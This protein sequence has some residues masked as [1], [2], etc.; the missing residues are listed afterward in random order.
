MKIKYLVFAFIALTQATYA[1]KGELAN[2]KSTY[3][4][5]ADLKQFNA[6]GFGSTSLQEAKTSIDK[7]VVH[8]K[9]INDPVAWGYKALIYTDLASLDS[10]ANKTEPLI[11]QATDAIKKASEL[12]NTGANKELIERAKSLLVRHQVNTGVLAY[13]SSRFNEAYTAFNKALVYKPGDTTVLYYTGLAAVNAK[14]YKAAIPN[15]EELLKTNYSANQRIYLD[16]SRLYALEKD[17]TAALRVASQGVSKYGNDVGLATQEIEL[18]LISGKQKEVIAKIISQVEKNPKD[19]L[20]PYY[21]GLAYSAINDLVK[22]EESYK[23]AIAI[24]STYANAYLNLGGLLLNKGIDTYNKAN[25]LPQNK[26]KEYDIMIKKAY[27]Q[28]DIAL[29]YLQK[30]VDL[31]PASR[32]GLENLKKYYIIK[33]NKIKSDELSDKIK[34][35]K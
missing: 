4:K 32:L 27:D 21:L 15:Y 26:Q 2:A 1:Q 10:V 5:Y 17:T 9:T 3:E 12:D 11:S 13:Q 28:F 16:L 14:N 30:A 18:S 34:V 22:A 8:V 33:K 20:Y 23:K 25:K 31:N 35:L 24:D 6:P 19:K 29:P 7:V